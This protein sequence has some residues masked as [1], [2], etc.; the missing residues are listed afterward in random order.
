MIRQ[1]ISIYFLLLWLKR[2]ENFATKC[3][4]I[5]VT[6]ISN[7]IWIYTD[8][9]THDWNHA[10]AF[11]QLVTTNPQLSFLIRNISLE[12]IM[13]FLDATNNGVFKYFE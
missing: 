12:I 13:V 4:A 5:E 8:S 6:D 9:F 1:K 7:I 2:L 3:L 10:F 11:Q